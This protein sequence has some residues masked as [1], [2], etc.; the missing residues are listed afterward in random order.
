MVGVGEVGLLPGLDL[1]AGFS[2]ALLVRLGSVLLG[3]GGAVLLLQGLVHV[4]W[5][6]LLGDDGAVDDV[7]ECL[8]VGL[9]LHGVPVHLGGEDLLEGK[10]VLVQVCEA[11]AFLL[12]GALPQDPAHPLVVLDAALGDGGCLYVQAA[13]LLVVD[14]LVFGLGLG[15][16]DHVVVDLVVL[17]DLLLL[18]LAVVEQQVL[19]VVLVRVALLGVAVLLHLPAD[20]VA[21][22]GTHAHLLLDGGVRPAA[23]VGT[24][25]QSGAV[26]PDS[27]KADC[28]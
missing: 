24:H 10:A 17:H 1:V 9:S 4:V 21:A 7:V 18:G 15:G 2:P 8:V 22:L 23:S 11:A 20:L 27:V 14:E 5:S 16:D 28:G 13:D 6:L 12:L 25:P 19:E 26:T 3:D